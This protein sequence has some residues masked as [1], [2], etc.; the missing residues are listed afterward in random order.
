M[1]VLKRIM[2]VDMDAFYASI[3]QRDHAEYRGKPLIVGG[4]GSRGVVAT[5][6]YEARAFGVHSAMPIVRARERCPQGIFVKPNHKLYQ[7]ISQQ[8]FTIFKEFSPVVEPLAIDEAFMDV[9]GMERL[10]PDWRQYALQLKQRVKAETGLVASVGIAPNKFLAKLA[11]D[12]KKPDGLVIIR[13][14]D[15]RAILHDLPVRALWGV[16]GKTAEVLYSMGLRTAGQIADTDATTLAK[17]IGVLAYQIVD[18]ANGRDE[19]EVN[20]DRAVQSIGNESTFEEDLLTREEVERNLLALA[21]KV[22]WR[23]RTAGC[24]A[25]T[26]TVKIRFASFATITRS[27]TLAE[28]THFDEEIY[29]AAEALYCGC[30]TKETIRLL[31]VVGSNLS[32]CVQPSLFEE[33]RDK[34]VLYQAVDALKARFGEKIITKAKLLACK[35]RKRKRT[36]PKVSPL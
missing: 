31:G 3:E 5:A 33:E 12:M 22:G 21:E 2:H 10:V 28:P 35:K 14:E 1:E 8:I 32:S 24:A 9:S 34:A 25:R 29:R 18:L 7:A 13:Q 11:S 23:L 15:A 4:I 17:H 36:Y 26:V 30:K 27:M 16:G 20:S 6:S 19:R